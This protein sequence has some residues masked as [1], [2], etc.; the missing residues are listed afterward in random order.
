MTISLSFLARLP[1]RQWLFRYSGKATA[2]IVSASILWFA[3]FAYQHVYRVGFLQE[4]I[5]ENQLTSRQ[6]QLDVARFEKVIE[7]M[8]KKQIVRSLP[9]L[10]N[11][12]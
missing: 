1:I 6:Q 4:S 11:P 2:L 3:W 10:R 5:G 8:K 12:F 7:A 9:P